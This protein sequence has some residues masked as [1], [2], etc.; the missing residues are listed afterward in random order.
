MGSGNSHLSDQTFIAETTMKKSELRELIRE[1]LL[2]ED[3]TTV[4][5]LVLQAREHI[6]NTIYTLSKIERIG[7]T[8]RKDNKKAI[9]AADKK[10][11]EAWSILNRQFGANIRKYFKK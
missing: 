6:E 11:S 5:N 10:L 4:A 1:E 3:D 8:Q 9:D 7:M 2:N